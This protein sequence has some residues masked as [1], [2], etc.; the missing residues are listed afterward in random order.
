MNKKVCMITG[1]RAEW[2]ILRPL[3]Q[4]LGRHGVQVIL[5]VTGSH[6]HAGSGFSVAEIESDIGT[7]FF[8]VYITP[9]NGS[10]PEKTLMFASMAAAIEKF[11][12]FFETEKPDLV[13]Y[14]GDRY[15]IYAAATACRLSGIRSA[16][17]SGGEVSLG[18]FDDVLRHCITK[19]SDLHFTATEEFRRRVIQLGENPEL[20]YNT[21]E[22][23]LADLDKTA[24]M[25]REQL[26]KDLNCSL[27]DFFLITLH[28]ETCSPGTVLK[29]LATVIQ[30]LRELYPDTTLV[31]TGAN[32]DPEGNAIN[33]ALAEEARRQPD[34]I[35]FHDN[36]GRLRYLS[37]ARLH[38]AANTGHTGAGSWQSSGWAA[39]QPGGDQCR[40]FQT[41]CKKSA[42]KAAGS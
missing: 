41:V 19:L 15:E 7:D 33:A 42:E 4:E 12:N 30:L 23:A 36:L 20:V 38:R 22:L 18:A 17:I 13:V 16:H 34:L 32:A 21:G 10:L 27:H 6:L 24:F 3:Y 5:V 29:G 37:A 9:E 28:P 1:S 39:A 25:S 2:G 31:F 40:L 11:A 14:Y 35:V 26:K 8:R